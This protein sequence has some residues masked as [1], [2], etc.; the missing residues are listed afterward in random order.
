[1][2]FWF[3]A[4]LHLGHANVIRHCA[5]PFADVADMNET[6]IARWNEK[7]APDD[8]VVVVGD[9]CFRSKDA[10]QSFLRRLSGR[11]H[12]VFGNHDSEQTRTA[13]G[14]T[15]SAPY[16]ELS[17][18]GR[19]V[20]AMHYA[21][22]TWNKIGKGAVMLHGHSH[23]RLQGFRVG[24]DGAGTLDVGVDCWDFAPVALPDVLRRIATLPP[25]PEF[26]HHAPDSRNGRERN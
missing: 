19:L 13:S 4:D 14:W 9:F 10:A 12:L 18:D 23:G 3:T 20:V 16:L 11:K 7:V 24:K 26:D 1:M 25:M 5:R 21:L 8:D 15:S 2:T 6:I 17:V 22:R